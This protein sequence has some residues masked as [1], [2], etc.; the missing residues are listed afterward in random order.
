MGVVF[1]RYPGVSRTLYLVDEEFIGREPD[2]VSR[3]VAVSEILHAAGFRWETSCR[4]DQ[5]TPHL[6]TDS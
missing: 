6:V 2:A 3:A 4:I 1:D 5:A